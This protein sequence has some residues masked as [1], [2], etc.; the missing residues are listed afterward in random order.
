MA[1]DFGL[2]MGITG[3]MPPV[4]SN[5]LALLT[6]MRIEVTSFPPLRSMK[7]TMFITF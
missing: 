2:I 7:R 4:T 5:F 3:K 6:V 1:L